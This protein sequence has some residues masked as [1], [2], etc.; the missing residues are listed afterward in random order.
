MVDTLRASDPMIV[1]GTS[2]CPQ[3]TAEQS[4]R[5]LAA[6]PDACL[7]LDHAMTLTWYNPAAA[8]LLGLGSTE[9]SVNGRAASLQAIA[10]IAQAALEAGAVTEREQPLVGAD[11]WFELRAV[12]D[13]AG[14]L[15]I[16]RETTDRKHHERQ[17]RGEAAYV[18]SLIEHGDTIV[19]VVQADGIPRFD[20]PLTQSAFGPPAEEIRS[21]NIFAAIHPD[22]V[23]AARIRFQR[24]IDQG[25]AS[26]PTV[27]RIRHRDGGWRSIESVSINLLSD[28]AVQGIL[29]ISRDVTERQ[30]AASRYQGVVEHIPSATYIAPIAGADTKPGEY[31]L[32]YISP[33]IIPMLGYAPED[34]LMQPDL[35]VERIH[36]DDR[37]RVLDANRDANDTQATLEIEYRLLASDNRVVWLR[38]TSVLLRDDDGQPE[39]W[40]GS[41][42]DI[43]EQRHAE[44]RLRATERYYRALVEHI[45]AVTYVQ[46]A[47]STNISFISSQ[48]EQLT[49]HSADAYLTDSGLWYRNI[50][51]DDAERV[52][53][54]IVRSDADGEPYAIE[55]RVRGVDGDWV[56]IYNA[57]ILERDDAGEPLFWQGFIFDITE[58]KAAE[59][60]QYEAE[61][62]FRMLVEQT[63][64]VIYRTPP[65]GLTGLLYISPQI[66]DLLGITQDE[67]Y[68]N[69]RG[70]YVG[71]LHPDDH[72]MVLVLDQQAAAD[73]PYHAEYRFV[74]R[75]GRVVWVRDEATLVY[76]EAGLPAFWQGVIFDITQ[77]K[78]L[79][80]QLQHRAFHD[81]L[82]GLPNR[83]LLLDRLNHALDLHARSHE[84]LALLFLDLDNFK[85]IN[86]SLGHT[87]GDMLLIEAARR[88]LGCVRSADTVAR[89]GG[90]EFAI[91]LTGVGGNDPARVAERIQ[92][93]FA[94]PFDI[95]GRELAVTTSIGIAY[96]ET[97]LHAP[98]DLLRRADVAMY[99]AKGNGRNGFEI[100]DAAM[101]ASALSRLELED[102]L[103]TAIEQD[104]IIVHFQPKVEL[105][106]GAFI[107]IEALARWLHPQ[108]GLTPPGEF[109]TLAEESG[110]IVPLGI[111][112]LQQ[113]ARQV[114]RWHLD[115]ADCAR[116]TLSVNLSARQFQMPDLVE[117]VVEVLE[118]TG[119][120]PAHLLLEI[121]ESVLMD[122]VEESIARLCGLKA[123][124]VEIAI[125]D[126]GTGYSS[127]AYLKRFPIDI[128]K[129]D[130]SFVAG[131][132][133]SQEDTAIVAAIVSMAKSLGLR[134]IA[135]GVETDAQV[136]H[137]TE[138]GCDLA[139]G[140]YF[141]RPMPAD[142]ATHLLTT[143][144]ESD[145]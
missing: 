17:H 35:W 79:E 68:S 85:I 112:V 28:P 141:A 19:T 42:L 55:Y 132:G 41:L 57:S 81:A 118:Q 62:D 3:A 49:S 70:W 142:D 116:L 88:L 129:I 72:D 47:N 13:A 86:D 145:T 31:P 78:E 83:A 95:D 23:A 140:F 66:H 12:P 97:N 125:D 1:P 82:T 137:L 74:A 123:L 25:G 44:D 124:G 22:D 11:R 101:H 135:E 60:R 59:Q 71:A 24:V 114:H 84:P 138:L 65:N 54:E 139:Q 92:R 105:A 61:R 36:P 76:D 90:D 80:E 77:R 104:E 122:D 7:T 107:G 40:L 18:R 37:D 53:A 131:L 15:V 111:S 115:L 9:P 48:V 89:F 126:F 6:L 144:G 134:T 4:A 127:L 8:Q 21:R 128:L 113:A 103:R 64:A 93:A 29:V 2:A 117:R 14:V 20:H 45:P 109:I 63:P 100:F 27:C 91:L 130:R 50:H 121:T 133:I 120:D 33:Q 30:R 51:P 143:R 26:A 39:C 94:Q 119:L 38:E 108:R 99:R 56:W 75:D 67:C 96:A 46:Y 110:L 16:L 34:W 136:T 98:D 5:I 58:R 87:E 106:S 69:P 43:T 32:E 102:E 73:A 10:S 52:R